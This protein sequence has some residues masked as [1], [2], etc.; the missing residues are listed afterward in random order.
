MSIFKPTYM[1]DRITDITPELFHKEGI[2]A[3]LLDVDN[4]LASYI[5]HEPVDG[6]IEWAKEMQQAGLKLIIVSNNYENRVKPFAAKFSLPYVTF[7]MKPLPFGYLKAKKI[8]KAESK[9]CAIVGDQILTDVIGA[10]LCG[11]KSILLKPVELES[12]KMF[13]FRRKQEQKLRDKYANECRYQP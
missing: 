2:S 8:L 10:N 6:A 1:M 7:S 9:E 3:V 11:M 4:T 13:Q 5:S 12:Q